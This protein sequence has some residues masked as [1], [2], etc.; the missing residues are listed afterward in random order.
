MHSSMA[1]TDEFIPNA[2]TQYT[3]Q[4]NMALETYIELG[5]MHITAAHM[6][7]YVRNVLATNTNIMISRDVLVIPCSAKKKKYTS[8]KTKPDF[9]V[10]PRRAHFL[11]R[12][13]T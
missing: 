3:E 2:K 11:C 5:P 6:Q 1:T 8:F 10:L 12:W 7:M 13:T 9:R 4:T